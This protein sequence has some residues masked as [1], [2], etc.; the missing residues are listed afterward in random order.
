MP[1]ADNNPQLKQGQKAER[2]F[3][4][5]YSPWLTR[6]NS[7]NSD[8][9]NWGDVDFK[10][11]GTDLGVEL[12]SDYQKTGNL[13]IE[14]WQTQER[15]RDAGPWQAKAKGAK[16][17]CYWA[18]RYD[19]LYIFDVDQLIAHIEDLP[20]HKKREALTGAH[21]NDGYRTVGYVIRTEDVDYVATSVEHLEF[22]N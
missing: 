4:E 17:Y 13:F 1:L 5:S 10:V 11:I 16:H 12:K 9:D 18:T 8:D 19:R 14:R 6:A 15:G 20:K 22:N 21:L 7:E 3:L 2:Q